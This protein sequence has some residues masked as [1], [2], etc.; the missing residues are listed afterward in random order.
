MLSLDTVFAVID[1]TTEHQRALDRAIRIAKFANA[2]LHAFVSIYSDLD[3]QDEDALRQVETS[4]YE[5]WLDRILNPAREEGL[6]ITSQI[7]WQKDW[8]AAI[9]PAAKAVNAD[10]IIKPSRAHTA[11]ERLLMKSSDLALFRTAQCPVL[12][13]K[14]EASNLTHKVLMAID[15]RRDDEKYKSIVEK[16]LKFGRDIRDCYEDGQLFAVHS[17]TDQ[18]EYVHVRDLAKLTGLDTENVF[19]IG[20]EP[21]QAIARKAGEIDAQVIVIGLSTKGTLRNR[22]FGSTGEWLLNNLDCDLLVIFPEEL[23]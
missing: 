21:E 12:L 8:F 7:E 14:S 18:E 3:T 17:Y 23:R 2:K 5:L 20:D 10:L 13:A 16:I 9:A 1:P 4:R 11:S 22:V 15:A 6:E 19:V